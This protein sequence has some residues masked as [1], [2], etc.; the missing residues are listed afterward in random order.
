VHRGRHYPFHPVYWATE[1]TFYPGWVP[2]KMWLWVYSTLNPPPWDN[3]V[4]PQVAVSRPG[5]V[6]PDCQTAL[7]IFDL[8]EPAVINKIELS[9]Y[10]HIDEGIKYLAWEILGTGNAGDVVRAWNFVDSP[11]YALYNLDYTLQIPVPPFT[12]TFPPSFIT[13]PAT[14]AEGGSPY[15]SPPIPD[16]V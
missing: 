15:P 10:T 3:L 7:Y 4:A 6:S 11:V 2:W 14:Y 13:R 1:S 5:L 16:C 9:L 8:E 12:G